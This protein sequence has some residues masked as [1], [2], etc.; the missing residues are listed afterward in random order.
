MNQNIANL[1]ALGQSIWIDY[2]RRGMIESGELEAIRDRGVVGL[3]SNPTI[4]HKAV[5]ESDDYAAALA[6][7][8]GQ[9][10]SADEV[11]ETLVWEDIRSAAAIMKPVFRR[12]D[13]VDGY[14]SI[15]VNPSLAHDTDATVAQGRRIFHAIGHPNVMIKV[16]ATP[17]G[18][19]AIE[20]LLAEGINVNVTLIFSVDVY[21]QVMQAYLRG[22][23][24][25]TDTGHPPS[26][27]ASV[28]SFFV[29]RI[30]TAVDA[31]LTEQIQ[32]G[33]PDRSPLLGKAAIA[34]SKLA[35]RA[36]QETFATRRGPFAELEARGARVQ[37]PLWASTSTKNPAY[38]D[39]YYVDTLIGPQTVNTVPPSTLD[40]LCDHLDVRVTVTDEVADAQRTMERL[41]D[42]G[43]DLGS[44][45]A[46]LR[47]AGVQ[48]FADSF[49][50]LM[51]DL[52]A[53]RRLQTAESG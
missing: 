25:F 19:P 3:T 31:R 26:G 2:I 11:Y 43:I 45:T 20:A 21:R 22:V 1:A 41:A 34:N 52:E 38:R 17:A 50:A 48:I 47:D 23:R 32:A 16:P 49:N 33:R 29:S 18:L 30:D 53:K 13:G 10:R 4:L 15:E 35:Y 7:C 27:V 8:I 14:V 51:A 9:A 37:R 24:R 44:V 42:A 28:A 6:G 40:A 12:T 5:T 39:T 36:F 46:A